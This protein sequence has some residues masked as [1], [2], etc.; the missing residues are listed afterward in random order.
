[1]RKLYRTPKESIL[2]GVCGGLAEH[3]N[4]DP[5][6]IR[7]GFIC[8]FLILGIGLIPYI[9]LAIIIPKKIFDN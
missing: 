7:I 4:I 3:L 2:F 5:I 8:S 6:L 1:M 9:L